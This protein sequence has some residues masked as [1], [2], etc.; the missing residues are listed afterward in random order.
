MVRRVAPADRGGGIFTRRLLSVR[1]VLD[2]FRGDHCPTR[3]GESPHWLPDHPSDPV[4]RVK[5]G[6]DFPKTARMAAPAS[7]VVIGVPGL[8]RALGSR[9]GVS[10]MAAPRSSVRRSIRPV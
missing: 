2:P 5:D 10:M 1:S 8:I 9:R 6:S 3:Q 4:D 7:R